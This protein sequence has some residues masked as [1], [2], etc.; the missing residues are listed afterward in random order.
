M[1]DNPFKLIQDSSTLKKQLI[2]EF[3]K[4]IQLT[5][6][7]SSEA[8]IGLGK[9]L[10]TYTDSTNTNVKFSQLLEQIGLLALEVRPFQECIDE[11]SGVSTEDCRQ[12]GFNDGYEGQVSYFQAAVQNLYGPF[13]SAYVRGFMEGN[14]VRNRNKEAR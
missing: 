14:Y 12:S 13:Q 6:R 3:A 8:C 7:I 11:E 9:V 4:D 5:I 10:A 1:H 2:P